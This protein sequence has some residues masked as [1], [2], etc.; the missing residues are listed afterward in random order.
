MG[1]HHVLPTHVGMV[2]MGW[3]VARPIFLV[4]LI[5]RL[6]RW[7]P[8]VGCFWGGP[9]EGDVGCFMGP[10]KGQALESGAV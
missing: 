10:A 3:E 9:S 5:R 2:R 6:W 4:S 7:A 1:D 8:R